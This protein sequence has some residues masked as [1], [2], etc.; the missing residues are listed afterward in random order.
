MAMQPR[1]AN[2]PTVP[3]AGGPQPSAR[4]AAPAPVRGDTA[5]RLRDVMAMPDSKPLP[6]LD[7]GTT[8]AGE[9][10]RRYAAWLKGQLA[11]HKPA[12]KLRVARPAAQSVARVNGV[13]QA[14]GAALRTADARLLATL[15]ETELAES[16]SAAEPTA[17]PMR[18][19]SVAPPLRVAKPGGA[20]PTAATT[21]SRQLAVA[22]L[23]CSSAQAAY[24]NGSPYFITRV[25]GRGKD[26]WINF[27]SDERLLVLTGCFGKKPGAVRVEGSFPRGHVDAQIVTWDERQIVAQV[28]AMTG[29]IDQDIAVRVVPEGGRL[30]SERIGH[31]WAK[32]EQRVLDHLDVYASSGGCKAIAVRNDQG[33]ALMARVPPL[34]DEGFKVE[35]GEEFTVASTCDIP[36]GDA[37]PSGVTHFKAKLAPGWEVMNLS[38]EPRLGSARFDWVGDT[39]FDVT[40]RAQTFT[41]ENR[42]F[43]VLT[44]R[45]T[46][47]ALEFYVSQ[48]LL[49]GPAGT[50]PTPT[51]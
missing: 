27:D 44:S 49:R 38:L 23:P 12:G 9:L 7:G 10:K 19:G 32:R 3:L 47:H 1:S 8:T 17:M 40:W 39:D 5:L 46:F 15:R 20:L 28:P 29:V 43:G 21:P 16:P 24:V 34:R 30:T 42:F 14:P 26:F 45:E 22:A 18:S 31:L 36:Q 51:R 41:T 6:T 50:L 33:S 13:T 4:L 48:M 25:N 11:A 35:F 2:S 37:T